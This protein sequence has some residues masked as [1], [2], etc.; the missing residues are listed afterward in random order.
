MKE[1][2]VKDYTGDNILNVL[3]DKYA[4]KVYEYCKKT[5]HAEFGDN[6]EYEIMDRQILL[7]DATREYLYNNPDG[8][9]YVKGSRPQLEK[10]VEE[11]IA[12]CKTEREKVLALFCYCRDLYKSE[13]GFGGYDLFMGGTEEDLI[14]KH[15]WF[16][17][18]VS[19]LMVGL[20]E[21]AGFPGRLIFHIAAGHMTCE[22]FFEGKWAYLDP[23]CGLFYLWED[24]SFMSVDEIINNRDM[25]YKQ[26]EYVKSFHNPFWDFEYRQHRNYHFCLSPNEIN[27]FTY[28]S[29]ADA[30]TYHFNWVNHSYTDPNRYPKIWDA[31]NR[32]TEYSLMTLIR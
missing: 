27:C 25:I 29:L 31:D 8:V 15:E 2:N 16:C 5:M 20:C 12:G 1:F 26:S 19:R 28:Y 30:D 6:V 22:I 32:L 9:K 13:G 10:V 21:I 3:Q 18:R 11:T 4:K 14:K 17:E 23:R 24:E 7:C